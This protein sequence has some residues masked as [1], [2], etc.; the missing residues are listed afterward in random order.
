[1]TRGKAVLALA[2][3]LLALLSCGCCIGLLLVRQRREEHPRASLHIQVDRSQVHV[4]DSVAVT[5]TLENEGRIALGL[6]QYRVSVEADGTPHPFEPQGPEAVEHYL[7]VNAGE[8]DSATFE[9]SATRS[10]QATLRAS[11]SYEVH[12][13]YPGPAYWGGASA[14]PVVL[15][16]IP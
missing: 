10:G 2:A 6:P 3:A 8:S 11:V 15:T 1:M 7:Q 13:G 14:G 12:L 4:G 5:V 9:L 16:V